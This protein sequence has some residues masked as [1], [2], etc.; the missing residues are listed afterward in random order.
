MLGQL[1]VGMGGVGK[2]QLA[3]AFAR[4]MWDADALD[5]LLWVSAA[6]R[7]A[8]VSSYTQ[9]STD[10]VLGPDG[11]DAEQAATRFLAWLQRT[12][13]RW[14]V[15]LDDVADA[16]AVRGL[17]PPD[18]PNGCTV[19]TSRRRDATLF[20]GRHLIEVGLFTEQ[21]AGDYLAAR[22]RPRLADDVEGVIADL[23]LLPLA[24]SH[25]AAYMLDQD[26]TCADYRR[27]YAD[28][29]RSLATL[30]PNE[31]ELFDSAPHTVATTWALSIEAADRFTPAGLARPLLALASVLDPN[32]IPEAVFTADS[33]VTLLTRASPVASA[34]TGIRDGLRSLHRFNL[35][36]H[37]AGLVRV[38][39]LVQ[40]V[41]REALSPDQLALM[42]WTT[43]DALAA[44]WPE[45]D[46]GA[47]AQLL[48]TNTTAVHQSVPGALW[49]PHH[50]AHPVLLRTVRSL[51]D[52]ALLTAGIQLARRFVAEA[53]RR[54]CA[55]HPD[56]FALRS[57]LVDLLG[58]AGELAEAQALGEAL[59]ADASRVLGPDHPA[60][61]DARQTLGYQRGQAG[62]PAAAARDLT[63]VLADRVHSLGHYDPTAYVVANQ[64]A[65]WQGK[66]G[67]VAGA[68]ACLRALLPDA[69]HD[70]G[71]DHRTTLDIRS[72][73][74][75][76]LGAAGDPAAAVATLRELLDDMVRALGAE[77]RDVS[78]LRHNLAH[79]SA[80]A[81]DVAG[82]A[83]ALE[84]LLVD[85]LRMFGPAH[86]DTLATRNRLA[87]VRTE[88]GDPLGAAAEFKEVLAV[89]TCQFGKDH[90]ETMATRHKLAQLYGTLGDPARAAAELAS[91]LADQERALGPHHDDTN[92]TREALTRWRAT[93]RTDD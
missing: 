28:R 66:A 51:G 32:G 81:G 14:L 79:W 44:I 58:D 72:N 29:S 10:L 17:W 8:V 91:I 92:A 47:D 88:L 86:R 84:P 56:T 42:A 27:R 41:A 11:E 76:W 25:A 73:F 68:V 3:A 7:D 33:S 59:V 15:V 89:Q 69:V 21:E 9:A 60:T 35:I 71:A 64:L 2:T 61:L 26:L 24:L 49:D 36:T 85:R 48:R 82:A 30:F 20:A 45:V 62:D 50:G 54:L 6:G 34:S 39:G 93:S 53:P 77:H 38:H 43:A 22:L 74:G 18:R 78:V 19:I 87:E 80:E 31:Q 75:F 40:R 12:H 46:Q 90:P 1:L 4:R 5:L 83:A 23:G 16:T 57:L 70:L 63:T 65:Y 52:A 67:D 55:D 13:K 37:E